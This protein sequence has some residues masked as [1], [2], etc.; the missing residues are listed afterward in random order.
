[1]ETK[2]QDADL[3]IIEANIEKDNQKVALAQKLAEIENYKKL[4]E[5]MTS[6]LSYNNLVIGNG[7]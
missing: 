3:D 6:I 2:L 5:R 4:K 1:M 7:N